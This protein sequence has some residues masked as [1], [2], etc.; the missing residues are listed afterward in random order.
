MASGATLY[1]ETLIRIGMIGGPA[2]LLC[3]WW[4][5]IREQPAKV[6]PKDEMRA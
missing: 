1:A 6:E 5:A 4:L 3:Y 2:T